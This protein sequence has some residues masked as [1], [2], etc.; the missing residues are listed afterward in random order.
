M[1]ENKEGTR[2]AGG[3]SA[4]YENHGVNNR[5]DHAPVLRLNC[6]RTTLTA[7]STS[8]AI[9]SSVKLPSCCWISANN[10]S[11]S[12]SSFDHSSGGYSGAGLTASGFCCDNQTSAAACMAVTRSFTPAFSSASTSTLTAWP[13]L[14]GREDLSSN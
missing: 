13:S 2:S 8:A 6:S 14:S 11:H 7:S 4:S 1:P 12:A 3:E 10:L 5:N 9:T